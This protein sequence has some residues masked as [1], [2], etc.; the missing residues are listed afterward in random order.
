MNE[1]DYQQTD[2]QAEFQLPGFQLAALFVT[3]NDL[4]REETMTYPVLKHDHNF[5][6]GDSKLADILLPSWP[7]KGM[8]EHNEL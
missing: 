6:V 3:A 4:F 2:I 1:T 8:E 5:Q 7:E